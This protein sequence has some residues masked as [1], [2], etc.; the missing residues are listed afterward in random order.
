[1]KKT[2]FSFLLIPFVLQANFLDDDMDGVENSFDKCPNTL[3]S[4]IVDK[5]GCAKKSLEFSLSKGGD[6]SLGY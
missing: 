3:F 4:D 6:I 5:Y 2:I 1:M